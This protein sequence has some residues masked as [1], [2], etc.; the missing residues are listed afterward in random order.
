MTT[1]IQ[2]ENK[3]A[4]GVSEG[5]YNLKSIMKNTQKVLNIPLID[6][7]IH[8]WELTLERQKNN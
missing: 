5:K 4:S 3:I 6:I 2:Q 1:D 7:K 8:T